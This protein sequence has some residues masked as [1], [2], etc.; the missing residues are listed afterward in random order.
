[1]VNISWSK[2]I[3]WVPF[4][5]KL[6]GCS[7]NCHSISKF[8]KLDINYSLSLRRISMNCLNRILTSFLIGYISKSLLK[9]RRTMIHHFQIDR[10]RPTP[11]AL[12]NR[13]GRL[14]MGQQTKMVFESKGIGDY[15][16][17]GASSDT[18]SSKP[19]IQSSR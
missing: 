19:A 3:F 2:R 5:C 17:G 10:S 4:E 13:L 11:T 1:M 15:G 9:V 12:R 18:C 14:R 6:F 16:S 7:V 8:C